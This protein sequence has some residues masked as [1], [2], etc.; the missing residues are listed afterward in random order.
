[1]KL[2]RKMRVWGLEFSSGLSPRAKS[3]T[4]LLSFSNFGLQTSADH[5]RDIFH[6]KCVSTLVPAFGPHLS[7]VGVNTG[8]KL[9]TGVAPRV[10]AA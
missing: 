7:G 1:M 4:G 6:L 8:Q 5:S 2:N 3:R 10:L 9:T